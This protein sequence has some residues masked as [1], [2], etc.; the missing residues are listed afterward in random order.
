MVVEKNLDFRSDTVTKPSPEMREAIYK[1]VE[2]ARGG[3]TLVIAG[4][5][6]EAQ[7]VFADRV[8]EFDDRRVAREALRWRRS[9]RGSPD[10]TRE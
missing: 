3:D 5:G 1:A 8:V 6:D 9:R 10:C 4:K 2:M 7:Q